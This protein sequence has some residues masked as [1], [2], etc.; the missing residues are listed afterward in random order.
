MESAIRLKAN[1]EKVIMNTVVIDEIRTEI[2]RL[3]G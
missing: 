2:N 3:E 1:G